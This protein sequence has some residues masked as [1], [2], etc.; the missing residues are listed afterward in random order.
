MD[1]VTVPLMQICI[2]SLLIVAAIPVVFTA[3]VVALELLAYHEIYQHYRGFLG[4]VGLG[5][6]SFGA[7][8]ALVVFMIS[9]VTQ[10][11]KA[12]LIALCLFFLNL[13]CFY[14]SVCSFL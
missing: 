12:T 7:V 1:K 14:M 4:N 8:S 5:L 2:Y 11:I 13:L 9:F 6:T 3:L 10:R